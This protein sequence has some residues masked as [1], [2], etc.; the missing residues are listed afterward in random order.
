MV[1]ESSAGY[2]LLF[3]HLGTGGGNN[4]P[5]LKDQSFGLEL[6]QM[7]AAQMNGEVTFPKGNGTSLRLTF[8]TEKEQLRMAS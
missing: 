8:Q 5:I 1:R 6:V 7:L 4:G 3:A 2:E